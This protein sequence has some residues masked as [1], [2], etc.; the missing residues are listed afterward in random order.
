MNFKTSLLKT[1][2]KFLVEAVKTLKKE[3]QEISKDLPSGTTV[4]YIRGENTE[5]RGFGQKFCLYKEVTKPDGF[6][7]VTNAH[8]I[9]DDVYVNEV[10][11]IE[12]TD[13]CPDYVRYYN[14]YFNM[15]QPGVSNIYDVGDPNG[16]NGRPQILQDLLLKKIT[17]F[18]EASQYRSDRAWE[19]HCGKCYN[20]DPKH[21]AQYKK[22]SSAAQGEYNYHTFSKSSKNSN[23]SG[24]S[25][26]SQKD[27][28][29]YEEYCR[30]AYGSYQRQN[31]GTFNSG[32]SSQ[33]SR[34]SGSGY[35]SQ[36]SRT[37]NSGTYSTGKIT[38]EQFV[39]YMVGKFSHLKSRE[40]V[41]TRTLTD[42]EIRNL[43]KLFKINETTMRNFNKATKRE[44]ILKYHPDT[45]GGDEMSVKIFQ[46]VNKLK[47][48]D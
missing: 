37:S 38:K 28:S 1:P 47:T 31:S 41:E 14:K 4:R 11:F 24:S 46:I 32:E 21:F 17:P 22:Y 25:Q 16:I 19:Q 45:N 23:S 20:H 35:S 29:K 26:K 5:A 27:Y 3:G 39:D 8:V 7:T 36:S 13:W 6:R 33:Y 12:P 42:P 9:R 15:R 18:N 43:A 10:F 34:T 30:Q 40:F 44:L 2:D 48:I